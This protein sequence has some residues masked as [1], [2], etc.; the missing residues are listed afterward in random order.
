MLRIGIVGF[1]FMGRMHYSNWSVLDSVEVTAICDTDPNIIENSKKACGNIEV[2][3]QTINFDNLKV[4]TNYE[5]MLS[6]G[7]V[8]AVS[9]TL[10]THLHSDFSIKAL[11][12]GLHVLCE[13]PMALNVQQCDD[14]IAAARRSGKILQIGHCV[15]FWPEYAK[16]KEIVDSGRYGKVIFAT[17]QRLSLLPTWSADNWLEDQK[18]SGG[19]ILDLHIHDSDYV[20]YLFGPPNAVYSFG[21]KN[22]DYGLTHVVT[23]YFYDNDNEKVVTA[24]GSWQMM[25]SF[26]FEMSFNIGLE[27]GTICYDC[28][29][30]PAFKVYPADGNAYTPEVAE[31]DGYSL[32]IAHFAQLVKGRMMPE[33]TTLEHSKESVRIVQAEIESINKGQ[34]IPIKN[35]A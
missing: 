20:Q 9:I 35:R 34:K 33:I 16:T 2:A 28:T 3:S 24:E 25:P 10:P 23:Q 15:R 26:V 17:F 22:T 31:G 14:M 32:E 19:M 7:I 6:D 1:G 30:E 4:Y 27:N 11:N 13:K 29:R 12:A 21:G 5:K 8:D 18:R